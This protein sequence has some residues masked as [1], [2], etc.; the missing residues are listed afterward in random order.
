MESELEVEKCEICN[1]SNELVDAIGSEKIIRVCRDCVEKNHLPIIEKPSDEQ[2]SRL[3]K[4]YSKDFSKP[5]APSL[6]KQKSPEDLEIERTIR[7]TIQ[8]GD[9]PDLIDNFHWHIQ[10]GR[11]MKK[12]SQKQLAESIAEPELM[13]DM[14][15]QGKLPE[16]HDKLISKL[17][18]FLKV[19]L[20]KEEKLPEIVEDS[21]ENPE[22]FDV[23]KANF[24]EVTTGYLKSLKDKWSKKKESES[25]NP[26]EIKE[27]AKEQEISDNFDEDDNYSRPKN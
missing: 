25:E 20:K 27:E 11:R 10:H 6:G 24:F 18:Q 4:F 15:E 12:L 13:I 22:E 2:L 19:K 14:A 21:E 3:H 1:E 23:K 7:K 9:F 16:N 17:E 5:P 26:E 8:S